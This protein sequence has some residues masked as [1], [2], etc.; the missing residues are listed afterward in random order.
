MKTLIVSDVVAPQ[1]YDA[2]IRSRF[3]DVE[4]VLSCGDV[5]HY[6]LEYIVGMLNVPLFYVMGNHGY[7]V[8]AGDAVGLGKRPEGCVDIHGRVVQFQGLTLAGLEG[9]MRYK[10]GPYQYTQAEMHLQTLQLML[11]L[12]PKRLR[13]G[14]W[15]DI[16][17][18]HAPP[19][20]VHDGSDLCH[21]GFDAFLRLMQ[22]CKPRYLVHGHTHVYRELQGQTTQY[23]ATT[24]V[25]AFPYRVLEI[26]T[27]T[28]PVQGGSHER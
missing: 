20:G 6:Y 15:F 21:T 10:N 27:A 12:L 5:P 8:E 2:G 3:S 24:V 23:G 28:T 26:T 4:L 11:R 22:R 17:L 16:L 13:T 18:T 7:E 25:N 9:S 19:L 14:R 1:I